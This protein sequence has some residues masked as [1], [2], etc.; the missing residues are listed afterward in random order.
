MKPID[1]VFDRRQ[2]YDLVIAF[3]G[4]EE[5]SSYLCRLGVSGGTKLAA[6]IEGTTGGSFT[7]NLGR[8]YAAGWSLAD[9]DS[10]I[11]ESS[12][13]I[14]SVADVQIA[15]DISSMPRVYL[16]RIVEWL[17]RRTGPALA[18]HFIYCPGDFNDSVRAASSS[19]PALTAKPVSTF[20][21]GRLRPS[22]VPLGL[23]VGIGL[24]VD[25]AAG[26]VELLEPARTWFLGASL[27]DDRFA[28]MAK[29]V[30]SGL[31]SIGGRDSLID[32]DVRSLS[33]TYDVVDSI[34]FSSGLDY[35]MILAPSG[36]KLLALACL[37]VAAPRDDARPA[38]WRVG[39]AAGSMPVNVREA[40]DVSASV[41]VFDNDL[42][43]AKNAGE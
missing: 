29:E 34:C 25:R 8:F 9:I 37:L 30:H 41:V 18:V 14:S 33:G 42:E 40:G 32:Y 38:V 24:E 7:E 31:L 4:Y 3:C 11:S 1:I 36:P 13:V 10:V 6:F 19:V 23:V 5:R 43:S 28:D 2:T 15:V 16:G 20:F 27:G 26:V 17:T 12:R 21:S 39:S 35:R 22:S